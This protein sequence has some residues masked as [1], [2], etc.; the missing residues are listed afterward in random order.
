MQKLTQSKLHWNMDIGNEIVLMQSKSHWN[1]EI[2][3]EIALDC[4][5]NRV[6]ILVESTM[7]HGRICL[8]IQE[9]KGR[10]MFC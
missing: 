7:V 2:V 1:M 10:T 9:T 8:K 5:T 4:C 6:R 3:Y